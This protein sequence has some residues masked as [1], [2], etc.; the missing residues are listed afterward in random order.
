[1]DVAHLGIGIVFLFVVLSSPVLL[2]PYTNP[3]VNKIQEIKPANAMSI[4]Y[5][6]CGVEGG[7]ESSCYELLKDIGI[8]E[9]KSDGLAN[10]LCKRN[11]K[12]ET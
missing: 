1:M 2:I 8:Q 10:L 7:D 3:T 4:D 9:G 11:R 12:L 5:D 6:L